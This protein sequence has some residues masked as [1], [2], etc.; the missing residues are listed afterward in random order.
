MNL[1]ALQT[2][3]KRFGFDDTDP[4]TTWLNAAMHEVVEEWNW[5]WLN[6]RSSV[7]L[8]S[9]AIDLT[10][11]ADFFRVISLRV[12]AAGKDKLAEWELSRFE[13][14]IEDFTATGTPILFT[15]VGQADIRVFPT[16]TESTTLRLVYQ[17]KISDMVNGVDTPGA[18]IIPEDLHYPIVQ[19]A[20][21]IALQAENEEDRA[22]AAL[23]SYSDTI[24]KKKRKYSDTALGEPRAVVDVMDY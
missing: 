21:A 11:P 24:D 1:T 9:G 16:P 6:T 14:E 2:A 17:R 22:V 3:L 20:A 10:L 13:R 12:D 4:L 7:V 15:T 18:G 5:P 19:K 8:A 23:Q